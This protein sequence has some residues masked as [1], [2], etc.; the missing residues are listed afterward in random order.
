MEMNFA[1]VLI[2]QLS[3]NFN[4]ND[5]Q[6]SRRPYHIVITHF[7]ASLPDLLLQPY[8]LDLLQ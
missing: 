1:M 3:V 2:S 7:E 4:I 6:L 5:F 8:A